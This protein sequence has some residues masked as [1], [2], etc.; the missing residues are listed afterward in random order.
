MPK[1][2]QKIENAVVTFKD[3]NS[4][5]FIEITLDYNLSDSTLDYNIKLDNETSVNSPMDFIGFLAQ[6]FLQ[7]LENQDNK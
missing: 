5:K 3:R 2:K 4:D 7:T 6:I 1:E